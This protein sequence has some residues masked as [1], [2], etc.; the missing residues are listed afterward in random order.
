MVKV[1]ATAKGYFGLAIREV[2]ETF[3]VPS[4]LWNDEKRRPSWAKLDPSRAFGGKGDHD[5]DGSVG[6]SRPIVA[7]AVTTNLGGTNAQ[8]GGPVIPADWS[9]LS[10]TKRK[11]L[12]KEIDPAF[13]GNAD[14]ADSLIAARVED[15]RPAP[16]SEA[17]APETAKPAGNGVQDALGGPQPDWVAPGT[18]ETG[19]PLPVDD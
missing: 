19:D 11:A 12:A 18:G 3:D 15:L 2:G 6:G 9:T 8:L 5:G 13:H 17:P 4:E 14:A 10:A 16:F 1:V 7:Q